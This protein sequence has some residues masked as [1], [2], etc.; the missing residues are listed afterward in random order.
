MAQYFKRYKQNGTVAFYIN[1]KGEEVSEATAKGNLSESRGTGT[2]H[3]SVVDLSE[4]TQQR[5]QSNELR[6]RCAR[7]RAK[8]EEAFKRS[9]MSDG[10]ARIAAK[11]R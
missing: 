5:T 2:R 8:L 6:T 1:E 9:G 4:S 3:R 11:G 7:S 10:E